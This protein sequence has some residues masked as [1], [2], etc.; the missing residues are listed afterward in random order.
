MKIDDLILEASKEINVKSGVMKAELF[1]DWLFRRGK[2]D[3]LITAIKEDTVNPEQYETAKSIDRLQKADFYVPIA[4]FM[5]LKGYM[6]ESEE[7]FRTILSITPNDTS[8][9]NDYGFV[10]LSELTRI[11]NSNKQWDRQR[12]DYAW[13][14]ISKAAVLDKEIH[15]EPLLLPAY[16]NLCFLRAVEATYYIQEKQIM[17]A[18]VMAWM[19]IEMTIYRIWYTHLKENTYS[20]GKM[21]SLK[22]WKIDTI[23][24]LLFLCKCDQEFVKLKDDLDTLKGLRNDLLHG[25]IFEITE[26]HAKRCVDVALQL[27]PIK[28]K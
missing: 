4:T 8:A 15:D 23:I 21:N 13:K 20:K 7:V 26:G 5:G 28:Q 10:I 16:K 27:I 3:S 22:K 19:S 25:T 14:Q 6:K 18:F 9:L 17:T 24:E 1:C 12:I 2:L 11:Y